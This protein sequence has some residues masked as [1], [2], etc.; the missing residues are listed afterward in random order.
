MNTKNNLSTCITDDN[1]CDIS[2]SG[3][4]KRVECDQQARMLTHEIKCG[5]SEHST[6]SVTIEVFTSPSQACEPSST[7][8]FT[9][10]FD[11]ADAVNSIVHSSDEN[12][13]RKDPAHSSSQPVRSKN[14]TRQSGSC[15]EIKRCDW[16]STA[17]F[18][19]GQGLRFHRTIRCPNRFKYLG[20][21]LVESSSNSRLTHFHICCLPPNR[22]EIFPVPPLL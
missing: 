3:L 12:L 6:S 19:S 5:M 2:S 8:W 1:H 9:P 14:K 11:L 4:T 20:K 7:S 21:C 17:V 13:V 15:R 18:E 16:C 10:N 22:C